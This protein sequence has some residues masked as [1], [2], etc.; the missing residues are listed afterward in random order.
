MA[1]DK[2]QLKTAKNYSEALFQIGCAQ[3]DVEKLYN[4]LKNI[5]EIVNS[6]DELKNF[7][8]NPLISAN[9]KKEVIYKV[10]GKDFDL[11]LINIMNLLAD[12]K[13]LALLETVLYCYEKLYEQKNDIAKISIISATEVNSN[14]KKRLENVLTQKTGKNII[15]E[16]QIKEDIISGIIIKINDT[17]IDLSLAKKIENMERQII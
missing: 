6:S 10:F 4:Q 15:P 8:K 7:F 11:Q 3:N 17:I 12:N 1:I 5:V 2:K 9:D 13:R 16:Y 14:L